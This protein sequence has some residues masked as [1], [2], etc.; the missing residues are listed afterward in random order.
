MQLAGIVV[1]VLLGGWV[2]GAYHFQGTGVAR[3]SRGKVSVVC[4]NCRGGTGYVPCVGDDDVVKG[5]VDAAEARE[6]DFDNHCGVGGVVKERSSA[7][8]SMWLRLCDGGL[9]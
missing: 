1:R 4:S 2:V 9:D 8:A 6:A 5:F 3:R 7:S